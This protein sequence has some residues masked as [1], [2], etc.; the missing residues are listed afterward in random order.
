MGCF[1]P[2]LCRNKNKIR[3]PFLIYLS[4]RI[5]RNY[6][7]SVFRSKT[8]RTKVKITPPSQ[9]GV[10]GKC[11]KYLNIFYSFLCWICEALI[12][13]LK[14]TF[15]D[16]GIWSAVKCIY[17]IAQYIIDRPE[18]VIFPWKSAITLTIIVSH[19]NRNKSHF[20]IKN[21]IEMM[22]YSVKSRTAAHVCLTQIDSISS[23]YIIQ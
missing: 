19:F 22:K 17:C 21:S 3:K 7:D 2:F 11:L 14:E 6:G 20:L 9:C 13:K 8:I 18:C 1:E 10:F 12:S 23:K 5:W 16:T 15:N 4:L